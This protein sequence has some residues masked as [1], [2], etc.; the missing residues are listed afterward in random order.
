MEW[1]QNIDGQ[2]Q[3]ICEGYPSHSKEILDNSQDVVN[4]V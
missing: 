3:N 2:I 1:S 4:V